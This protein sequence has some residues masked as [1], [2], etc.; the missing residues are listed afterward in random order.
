MVRGVLGK[1][2]YMK[3]VLV[4]ITCILFAVCVAGCSHPKVIGGSC[5]EVV[6][7][8]QNLSG[9]AEVTVKGKVLMEGSTKDEAYIMS[10]NGRAGEPWVYV[11]FKDISSAAKVSKGDTIKVKGVVNSAAATDKPAIFV[12]D[13][14]IVG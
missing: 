5:S 6:E 2:I 14:V 4:L 8:C 13:A 3:K 9:S 11:T 1:E 10:D 12:N 7:A